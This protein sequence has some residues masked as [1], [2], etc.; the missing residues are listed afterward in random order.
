MSE[1]TYARTKEAAEKMG[2]SV[3]EFMALHQAQHCEQ[4]H[5]MESLLEALAKAIGALSVTLQRK[6]I[7]SPS[8][9]LSELEGNQEPTE[10][11]IL[12]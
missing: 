8:E 10:E 4:I 2:V 5:E 12:H 11:E 3:V 7:V 9:L 6:G 1:E